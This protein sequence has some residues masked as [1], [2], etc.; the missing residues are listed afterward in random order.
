MITIFSD[1]ATEGH[2]GKLGTVKHCGIGFYCPEYRYEHSERIEA[3]SNNEAEFHALIAAMKWAIEQGEQDVL[4]LLDSKIVVNRALGRRPSKA[5]FRNERMDKFQNIVLALSTQFK[6]GTD[7]Q[8][9]PRWANKM[10][11]KL[12]KKS[13][14]GKK[15]N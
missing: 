9:I 2:N 11:D 8:W 1:G 14:H 13:L 6:V 10:A 3:I 7:F 15:K 5:K 4:F 12:S